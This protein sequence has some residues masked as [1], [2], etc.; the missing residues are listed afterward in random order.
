MIADGRLGPESL[1][2]VYGGDNWQPARELFPFPAVSAV[3]VMATPLPLPQPA[4]ASPVNPYTA[5]AAILEEDPPPGDLNFPL[6]FKGAVIPGTEGLTASQV[7]EF[8]RRGGRFVIWQYAVSIV[9][10][11]FRRNSGIRFIRPGKT[12]A[13]D[14]LK[15]SM[16]SGAVGWWGIPWGIFWTLQSLIQNMSGGQDVTEPLLKSI[17]GPREADAII[18]QKRSRFSFPVL[19]AA[20]LAFAIPISII[21]LIG[22]SA[23][24][25]SSRASSQPG[26]SRSSSSRVH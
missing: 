6:V 16:I 15:F 19:G 3:P 4:P 21:Y 14:C 24:D 25:R 12:G 7:V 1:V 10:V 23:P 26:K 11:S 22:S 8:C 2:V 17:I 9:V 5:P 18:R 13:L 20:L